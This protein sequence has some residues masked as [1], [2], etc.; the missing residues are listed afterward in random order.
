MKYGFLEVPASRKIVFYFPVTKL[1]YLPTI[2]TVLDEHLLDEFNLN[3]EF[4]I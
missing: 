2:L 3:E 1:Q 4:T